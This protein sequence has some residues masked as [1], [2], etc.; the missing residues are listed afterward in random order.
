M[1]DEPLPSPPRVS[2]N[3][4]LLG[5][6]ALALVALGVAFFWRRAAS[7]PDTTRVDAACVAARPHFAAFQRCLLGAPLR[8]G[9][10][11][12]ER[13]RNVILANETL[14]AEVGWPRRCAARAQ[15]VLDEITPVRAEDARVDQLVAALWSSRIALSRGRAPTG[16]DALWD[17][18]NRLSITGAAP[19]SSVV[20]ARAPLRPLTAAEVVSAV[21]A[22][23][24]ERV[25]AV[26]PGRLLLA[27]RTLRFCRV[28]G[29]RIACTDGPATSPTVG[30]TLVESAATNAS[31]RP[32][33]L[34]LVD[35]SDGP[36]RVF[37][38]ASWR[39]LGARERTYGAYSQRG[40][41]LIVRASDQPGASRGSSM[42][43]ES[44]PGAAAPVAELRVPFSLVLPPRVE[45]GFVYYAYADLR[46]R[47]AQAEVAAA[48]ASNVGVDWLADDALAP[49]P[50]S[51]HVVLPTLPVQV[52]GC[53]RDSGRSL[54][55]VTAVPTDADE[56]L[57]RTVEVHFYDAHGTRTAVVRGELA[58]TAASADCFG[59][60][61]AFLARKQVVAQGHRSLRLSGLRCTVAGCEGTSATLSPMNDVPDAVTLGDGRVLIVYRTAASGGLRARIAPLAQLS[62]AREYVLSDEA[63]YGGIESAHRWLV[64]DGAGALLVLTTRAGVVALR[65]AGDGTVALLRP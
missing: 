32:A 45:A 6:A 12:A 1:K 55:F 7:A 54:A 46:P 60:T 8:R 42:L 61:A 2:A 31:V 34:V 35:A 21:L 24:L 19:L 9:E 16:I 30:Y 27:G 49:R 4:R 56:E 23:R 58:G 64:R 39:E 48:S 41:A 3:S 52:L 57:P 44:L 40:G 59:E 10:K 18:A 53:A 13:L 11:P 47:A 5:L 25:L 51:E 63:A 20:S 22:P 28:D 43:V 62:A 15:A 38:A 65:V 37:D 17:A 50:A 26:E 14:A 33:D 36:D 29:A